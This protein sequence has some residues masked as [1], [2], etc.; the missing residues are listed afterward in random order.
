MEDQRLNW[1]K[2]TLH[3][4]I[5]T[6]EWLSKYPFLCVIYRFILSESLATIPFVKDHLRVLIDLIETLLRKFDTAPFSFEEYTIY[7]KEYFFVKFKVLF[8]G[9][10]LQL[11]GA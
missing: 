10:C 7:H 5:T 9:H 6:A 3:N 4:Y 11:S 2:K 8:V 1:I